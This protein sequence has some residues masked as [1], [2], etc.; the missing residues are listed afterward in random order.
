MADPLSLEHELAELGKIAIPERLSILPISG[1]VLFPHVVAPI[2]VS[3]D[4]YVQMVNE[5]VVKDRMLALVLRKP[6][7][8]DADELHGVGTVGRILKFMKLPNGVSFICQGITRIKIDRIV[9]KEPYMV[10]EVQKLSEVAEKSEDVDALAA[11]VRN[12]FLHFIEVFPQIPEQA[13]AVSLNIESPSRLCDFIMANA[14][15]DA[16]KQQEMLEELNVRERLKKLS[17]ILQSETQKV[18][19]S[20]KIQSEIAQEMGDQQ[21]KI[22]LREQLKKIQAELGEKDDKTTEMDNLRAK[23]SAAKMTAE[24]EKIANKELDRL[25]MMSP[26]APEYSVSRTYLDWL[27]DLPWSK[28]SQDNLDIQHAAK[29]LDEDHYDLQKVKKR[30]I[31][32]LAVRKLKKD[33]KGPI[34]CFVGPPGVGKTSLGRSIA[35]SMGREFIRISLGGVRDE[36]EIRGHR[37]TYVAAL[38]GRIVQNLRKAGKN[39]PVFMLDEID[40]LGTDFRGDPSSA[41][42]EVLDPEQNNSFSDHYL[43]VVFDLSKVFF[44]ATAN[45]LDTVPPALRDRLEVLEIP[46]YT[47]EEKQYIAR[48]YIVPRQLREHGLTPENLSIS[49]NAVCQIIRNYTRESGVRN[50]EREIAN[51]CRGV[52]RQV[53]EGSL[54]STAVVEKDVVT[55]LGRARFFSEIAERISTAGIATGLAWTPAGGDILFIEATRMKGTKG[56]ILTGQLGDVMK[57]SAQAG[58]SYVR[59]KAETFGLADDFYEKTDIHLH[60]PAGAIPKDGPSAGVTMVCA[61]IS[62]LTGH[63]VRSDVAMTGEITLRGKVLPVGGI[64]EKVLAAKRAGINTVILPHLNEKDLDETPETAKKDMQFIFADRIDDV[65]HAAFLNAPGRPDGYIAAP[66]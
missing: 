16:L 65:I 23:I 9:Q 21:R 41:L 15:A 13:G 33:M 35:R 10:A 30:I 20:N 39:N 18:E 3:S 22:M 55:Y 2:S 4:I 12:M 59:S 66:R 14:P 40:K 26:A 54:T 27:T 32:Y 48:N 36:A 11:S 47:E 44:I 45:I 17:K 64:K 51:I 58:L 49:D 8:N 52:A 19:L 56:L 25:G 31:E 5:V 60:V 63:L 57:E 6:S 42:L 50:M 37:R 28:S 62:M 43:E 34:L 24:A 53:A 61:L 46:G 38:P 7:D 1:F 29:I